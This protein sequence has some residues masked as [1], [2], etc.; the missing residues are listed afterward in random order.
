MSDKVG[1]KRKKYDGRG[2][3][4]DTAYKFKV[5]LPNGVAVDLRLTPPADEIQ[6]DCFIKLVQKKYIRTLE[7]L[8]LEPERDVH[9]IGRNLYLQDANDKKIRQTIVFSNFKSHKCHILRLYVSFIDLLI[10]STVTV[11]RL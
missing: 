9:W 10:T 4:E 8:R 3:G 5:M 11:I 7:Q 6:L 2:H 1:N